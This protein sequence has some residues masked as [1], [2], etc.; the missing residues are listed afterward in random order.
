MEEPA[1]RGRAQYLNLPDWTGLHQ[2]LALFPTC[3][4]SEQVPSQ[5]NFLWDGMEGSQR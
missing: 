4:N 3:T 2:A 1:F 5:R